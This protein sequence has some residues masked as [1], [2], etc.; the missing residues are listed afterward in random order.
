MAETHE[1]KPARIRRIRRSGRGGQVGI[2]LGKQLRFFINESDWK[3][4]IMAAVIAGLVGMV[5]RPRL[6]ISMEGS[7]MGGF[8]L[9]CVAIWNGCFN[10]IQCVCRERQI[11]KREHRSGMHISSYVTAHMI[12]QFLLCTVQTG[13]TMYVLQILEIQ[14]PSKGLLTPWMI[15]DVGIS[16]LLI[17][18]AADMMSLFISSIS[19]TTTAAMTVMPFVLIFQLVFS[20]GVIPLPSW[21]REL[22]NYT[23][24]NYG[25]HAITA[26][27]GYN[28][29]PMLTGWETLNSMRDRELG[30]TFTVED[31]L[32]FLNSKS[33]GKYRDT[34]VI[35][36]LDLREVLRGLGAAEEAQTAPAPASAENPAEA[37]VEIRTEP[38][39]LGELIDA[40][41]GSEYLLEHKDKSFTVQTTI[42]N[43]LE[44]FG[45]DR[46][47]TAVQKA[48]AAASYNKAYEKTEDNI[49]NN[50]MMLGMFA[51][52]FAL[53]SVISLEMIDRDKR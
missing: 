11:I 2:Y 18:Y 20:G 17:S 46:V 7:L 25:I 3:V 50:W 34:E 31:V 45:E 24:S 47:R 38:V 49:L 52:L 22:S 33:M 43:I 15:V 16:M 35:P 29:L 14:F 30:G 51:M 39:T 8:S 42:G 37:P 41:N 13:V 53:L 9:T 19:H 10:S 4:L 12:Y 27:A 48:T 21:S 32:K 44:L 23:I 28:E 5:V 26:Q 36:S 1:G 40:A 6:F